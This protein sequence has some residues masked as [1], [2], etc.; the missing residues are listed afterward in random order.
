[1]HAWRG[2]DGKYVSGL[3]QSAG[4]IR[5]VYQLGRIGTPDATMERL[6]RVARI[7]RYRR[8]IIQ[9]LHSF[10]GHTRGKRK[11]D[12]GGGFA[13][14]GGVAEYRDAGG[15]I[16]AKLSSRKRFIEDIVEPIKLISRLTGQGQIREGQADDAV[17][18]GGG[19][20]AGYGDCEVYVGAL[21]PA[22]SEKDLLQRISRRA[23]GRGDRHKL[24]IRTTYLRG[25]TGYTRLIF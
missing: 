4:G 12:R 13:I 20:G 5:V 22:E 11:R 21:R 8:R 9:G 7:L 3:F 1:M 18:R 23:W 6:N 24:N 16:L 2:G 19:G 25:N 14:D 17:Y 15:E 10:E